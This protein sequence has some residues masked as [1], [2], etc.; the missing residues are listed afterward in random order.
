MSPE[1]VNDSVRGVLP[2][3]GRPDELRYW[4]RVIR[5]AALCHDLGH[6]PF[7][8]ASEILLPDGW[9]HERLTVKF[10]LSEEM[11]ESGMR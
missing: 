5:A 6:L 10:I 11:H 2:T 9:N 8:H 3:L 1:N 4:R 7:S